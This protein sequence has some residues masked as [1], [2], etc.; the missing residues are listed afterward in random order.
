VKHTEAHIIV[1]LQERNKEAIAL[2]YDKWA[3]ALFG[4]IN[5]ICKDE[6]AAKDILQDT[7]IKVWEKGHQ[8]DPKKAKLFT[9]I[10]QIARNKAIDHYRKYKKSQTQEIH[11]ANTIVSRLESDQG[12]YNSELEK[13]INKLEPKYQDV[14]RAFYYEGLTHVE[15]S[16]ETGIALGT[17]KTRL[18]IAL[19]ELREFY[20]EPLLIIALLICWMNG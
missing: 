8:Y 1:L 11:F 3:D 17:I 9:W 4:V 19:R 6:N 16:K 12:L 13:N 14:L 18:R 2:M 10:Y 7:F 5:N 20:N 15:M